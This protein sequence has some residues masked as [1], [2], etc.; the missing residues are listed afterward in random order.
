MLY[1]TIKPFH[2]SSIPQKKA[3]LW[4][5]FSANRIGFLKGFFVGKFNYSRS[6]PVLD[7]V[8]FN[9]FSQ[10]VGIGYHEVI[11]TIKFYFRS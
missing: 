1:F 9:N 6:E 5:R 10:D 3:P 8:C 11:F 7:L 2:H 4:W